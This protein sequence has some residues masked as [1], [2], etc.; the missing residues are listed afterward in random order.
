MAEGKRRETGA[1]EPPR[2]VPADLAAVVVLTALML[3]A[4]SLPGVRETP[5]R[6]V[7]G[8]P[9]TLFAPGYAIVAALFPEGGGSRA[10][11]GDSGV[12]GLER[13]VFSIGTSVV[14]VPL[15][16]LALT[17]TPW[18][19]RLAP[20]ALAIAAV[21]VVAAVAAALRRRALP[22]AER[23]RLPLRAWYRAGR[24]EFVVSNSRTDALVNAVLAV[25]VLLAVASVAY[26]AAIPPGGEQ[27]TELYLVSEDDGNVTAADYPEQFVRG[28]GQSVV[29]GIQ[30]HERET[31]EYTVVVQLQRVDTVDDEPRVTERQQLDRLNVTLGHD[32]TAHRE[33]E[34]APETTGEN[35][36]VQYLLYRGEP[37][38]EPTA[39][40]AYRSVHLWI[41][42]EE[43]SAAE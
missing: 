25:S 5:L 26:A 19:I 7:L 17:L 14:V 31:V 24:D 23:F 38:A 15:S 35:L 6:I 11:A 10:E 27:F 9:F 8:V 32:E 20:V 33:H 42:V 39:E 34:I 22:P 4:V 18:G 40:N 21:T 1:S 36:R 16:G 3:G 13:L 41:D 2:R 12:D 37:P 28:E 43:R 29:I 30:N